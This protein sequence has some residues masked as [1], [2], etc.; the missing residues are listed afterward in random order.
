MGVCMCVFLRGCNVLFSVNVVVYA[1]WL[2]CIAIHR[3]VQRQLTPAQPRGVHKFLLFRSL[4]AANEHFTFVALHTTITRHPYIFPMTA[5]QRRLLPSDNT[6]SPFCTSN[7]G[8]VFVNEA[9]KLFQNV[10]IICVFTA[11]VKA[12]I[13]SPRIRLRMNISRAGHPRSGLLHLIFVFLLRIF[14][15]LRRYVRTAMRCDDET[16]HEIAAISHIS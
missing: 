2:V 13:L 11:R 15:V 6:F 16:A 3:N 10:T 5:A 14:L 8:L 7:K 1:L 9:K 12:F 4:V